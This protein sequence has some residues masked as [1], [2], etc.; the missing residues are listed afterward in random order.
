MKRN[1]VKVAV[2]TDKN[3]YFTREFDSNSSENIWK[4]AY[5]ILGQVDSKAPTH[6]SYFVISSPEQM[7][8]AFNEIFLSKVKKIREK[9]LSNIK[10][11]DPILRLT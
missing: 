9:A 2:Q 3:R 1:A 4:T 5:K 6:I 7:A 8:N 11:L 10:S